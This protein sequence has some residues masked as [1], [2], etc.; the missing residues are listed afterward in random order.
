MK[1]ILFFLA[2]IIA[3]ATMQAQNYLINFVAAGSASSLDSVKIEN[4]TQSTTLKI[5]GGDILRLIGQVGINET[6]SNSD[7]LSIS[8]N[9]TEGEAFLMFNPKE[10]GNIT[11]SVYDLNGK[12]IFQTTKTAQQ[13]TQ[14]YL[15]N[16][17]SKGVYIVRIQGDRYSYSTKLVSLNNSDGKMKIENVSFEKNEKLTSITKNTNSTIDMNYASGDNLRFTGYSS[18]CFNIVIDVPTGNKTITYNFSTSA[19]ILNTTVASNITNNSS[20]TGGEITSDGSCSVTARGICYSLNPNPTAA[21]NIAP[22]GS[23]VGVFVVNLSGLTQGTKYYAKAYATNSAGTSYGNEINFTTLALPTI[24]TNSISNLANTTAT[25]GG[26]ITY[27]GGDAITAK[28][29]CW[30]ISQN[31]TILDAKTQDGIGSGAFSSSMTGL[32]QNTTYY[33]RAYATNGVGTS[34]GNQVS[35][36]TT[37]FSFA[38]L[39]TT[40][41]TSIT[42]ISATTGGNI[43]N[44]GGATITTRGICWSK[45]VN[46]TITDSVI[47]NGNGI[48]S[49]SVSMT[50]LSPGTTYYVRAFATNV[51]GT[52]YGNEVSF[53]TTPLSIGVSYQGGIV[54][55]IFQLGD[56]GYIAGETHGI[57]ASPSDQSSSNIQWGCFSTLIN[58][59]ST[60][61]GSGSANTTSIINGCAQIGIAARIC[62]A[63]TLNGYT[64]WVLPSK[65]EL[66]KLYINR[67]LIGNFT[68]NFYWSSSEFDSEKAIGQ[69]FDA[70]GSQRNGDKA[71]PCN[72]R[73]IRN[74]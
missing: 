2:L 16:G 69:D 13:T 28:G 58:G 19:P 9:P 55:Y 36:T 47:T 1:K 56:P 51:A 5:N 12:M 42:L 57:I 26:N 54:A 72:V 17:F 31:P 3:S 65:D 39:T 44:D 23:G 46:P 62:D 52:A 67:V 21:N 11:L 74:F 18:S 8:P 35:F 34:Y 70:I 22:S 66:N 25:C 29:V 64:D 43:T 73:A 68:S 4:L 24:T 59:T 20:T 32:T 40:S 63:L 60:L 30:S 41:A 45:S 10:A 61:L 7:A 49:F 14:K 15:I 48:G 38:T 33:V 53:T 71:S 50:N 6:N 27:D 37:N